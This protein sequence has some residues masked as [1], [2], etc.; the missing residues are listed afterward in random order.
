MSVP[1]FLVLFALLQNIDNLVLAGAYRLNSISIPLRPNLVIAVLSGLS[2]GGAVILAKL[3]QSEA[4]RF[5][6]GSSSEVVG[7][8]ILVM[9]GVW[10]LVGYFRARLF[11]CLEN[12]ESGETVAAIIPSGSRGLSGAS[13]S[14]SAV[15]IPGTALAVDNI[16]PSF[17]FGLVNAKQLN[18]VAIGLILAALTATCSVFSVWVGQA[19]GRSGRDYL[20]WIS[21]ELASGCLM[22]AI[23]SLD[24][25]DFVLDWIQR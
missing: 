12:S 9:I 11:L 4:L 24:P 23:A 19:A 1:V 17:A 18:L 6:F 22:I 14:V 8:S 16:A 3:S 5:G 20:R 13:M 7:R 15:I 25:G 2:T 21:P 10:T